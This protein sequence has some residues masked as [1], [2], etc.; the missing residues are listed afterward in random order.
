MATSAS[1][2]TIVDAQRVPL[3]ESPPRRQN[4]MDWLAETPM[5]TRRVANPS[6]VNR[7][8]PS[9]S[10]TSSPGLQRCLA[11]NTAATLA[12]PELDESYEDLLQTPAPRK[13]QAFVASANVTAFVSPTASTASP[14]SRGA[15][16]GPLPELRSGPAQ[17]LSPPER[18]TLLPAAPRW[19][20]DEADDDLMRTPAPK[21]VL[22][23]AFARSAEVDELTLSLLP[24]TA[25]SSTSCGRAPTN[26]TSLPANAS[27][28]ET[29][30]LLPTAPELADESCADLLST[31]MP[32]SVRAF[33]HA[34][35]SSAFPVETSFS[36][37]TSSIL[38]VGAI[39]DGQNEAEQTTFLPVMDASYDDLMA[40]PALQRVKAFLIA[41]ASVSLSP[42]ACS[43]IGSAFVIDGTGGPSELQNRTTILPS[44]PAD[45]E[46]SFEDLMAT[47]APRRVQ[48]LD[49]DIS[50]FPSPPMRSGLGTSASS[51]A[52]S[53]S[54][55]PSDA[56]ATDGASQDELD[57]TGFWPVVAGVD[58]TFDDLMTT[59]APRR[60]KMLSA[61]PP[62]APALMVSPRA[63]ELPKDSASLE[64]RFGYLLASTRGVPRTPVTVSGAPTAVDMSFANDDESFDLDALKCD[65]MGDETFDLLSTPL[66]SL[67]QSR[68]SNFPR[69]PTVSPTPAVPPTPVP[70]TTADTEDDGDETLILSAP[71]FDLH[72]ESFSLLSGSR[73]SGLEDDDESDDWGLE[74]ERAL[75]P[76]M[77]AKRC[78]N[79][80]HL[81]T[82]FD[83][84]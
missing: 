39:P 26:V 13:P 32:K 77:S 34:A 30:T 60:I 31:P 36:S 51:T 37:D 76:V 10:D 82:P 83:Q 70:A 22:D 84:C 20:S 21:K 66:P 17:T 54:T 45:R 80:L 14:S 25:S 46:E 47:P 64:A 58:E 40:T 18:T 16:F 69:S 63:T 28:F 24:P 8:G 41:D 56:T 29:T 1:L 4:V 53:T 15:S 35:D 49:P 72:D 61:S 68:T 44:F 59:P 11:D 3:P 27:V 43:A 23:S 73:P 71:A 79:P 57:Q 5:P 12:L 42:P 7:S 62:S 75:Q 38:T 9:S 74:E 81:Q 19:L 33:A 78:A 67:A 55:S 2:A 52:S 48:Q 65:G 50:T 6:A